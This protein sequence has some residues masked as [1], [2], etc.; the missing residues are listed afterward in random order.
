MGYEAALRTR[1]SVA[2]LRG[3]LAIEVVCAAQAVE[4]RHPL[5]AARATATVIASLRKRTPA[6]GVDR[7]L[8]GDLEAAE[9][10]ARDCEWRDGL[11]S[12]GVTLR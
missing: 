3:V 1:R 7:I 12:V 10:W 5:Q 8:S 2:L 11:D 4:M 6:L 9:A